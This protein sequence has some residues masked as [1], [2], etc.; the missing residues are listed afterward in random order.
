MLI[1]FTILAVIMISHAL[2]P[3]IS[4]KP[5]KGLL[6]ECYGHS[7]S[8]IFSGEVTGEFDVFNNQYANAFFDISG[9]W[10]FKLKDGNVVKTNANCKVQ[11]F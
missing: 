11:T 8:V 5:A 1:I 6:V 7:Q 2:S 10:S 4:S 9:L 3:V